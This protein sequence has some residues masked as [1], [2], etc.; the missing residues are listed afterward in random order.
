MTFEDIFK[1]NSVLASYF[2]P[3][4]VFDAVREQFLESFPLQNIH[5]KTPDGGLRTIEE[6]PVSLLTESNALDLDLRRTRLFLRFAV[7]NCISTDEYRAK[8]RPLLRQW[9]PVN[10]NGAW[11]EDL[12]QYPMPIILLYANSEVIDSKLFK[13]TSLIDKFTKDFPNVNVLEI[14]TVYKSPKEKKEFW[15]LVGQQMKGFTLNVF[16]HRLTSYQAQL[17]GL[18][19]NSP[20]KEQLYL[21]ESILDLY[22]AL[23]LYEEATKELKEIKECIDKLTKGELPK[24][25][26]EAPFKI[27][28]EAPKEARLCEMFSDGI[29]TKYSS[30]KYFF[31]KEFELLLAKKAREADFLRLYRL[32]RLFLH[33]IAQNYY[34]EANYLEFKFSLLDHILGHLPDGH[35]T[36]SLQ[37]QAELFSAKRD[38]WIQGVLACSS[39]TLIGNRTPKERKVRTF[40]TVKHTYSSEDVFYEN[41]LKLTK[42]TLS[43]FH[44]CEGK[45]Q[46]AADILSIEIGLLHY[47]REEYE[48]AVTLFLSCYEYYMQFKWDIIGL[49]LLKIFVESLIRCPDLNELTIDDEAVPVSIILSNAYLNIL[50]TS[51]SDDERKEW[52]QKFLDLGQDRPTGLVYATDGLFSFQT[53]NNAFY[54]EANT[55]SIEVFIDILGIPEDIKVDAITLSFKNRDDCFLHFELFDI[56]LRSEHKNKCTLNTSEVILGDF[57]PV[58]LEIDMGSTTFVK[59]FLDDS[60]P[61]VC[62]ERMYDS[63]NVQLEI[64]QAREL[65]LGEYALELSCANHDKITSSEVTITVLKESQTSAYPISFRQDSH[66]TSENIVDLGEKCTL[67]YFPSDSVNNFTLAAKFS[68]TTDFSTQKFSETSLFKIN[69][70]LPVSVSVEDIF[71]R[72]IFFFKF[73]LGS[74]TQDE[75]VIV[76]RT[77]LTPPAKGERYSISGGFN[78]D[79][80]LYLSADPEGNCLNCYQVTTSS[81]FQPSDTFDLQI[82]YSTLKEHL[83]TLVTDAVLV[84]GDVE[85]YRKFEKWKL[86]WKTSILPL[87]SY[88]YDAYRDGFVIQLMKDSLDMRRI[89]ILCRKVSMT[90]AVREPIILCLNRLTKGVRLSE[91]DIGAY[92]K[93]VA[94]KKLTVPVELPKFEQLFLVQFV[95]NK[96]SEYE[97]GDPIKITIIIENLNQ[98]WGQEGIAGSFVF[99]VASSNEWLVNGKRRMLITSDKTEVDLHIIPLK[100]GYLHYPKVEVVNIDSDEPSRI[101]YTN[102]YDTL[103]VF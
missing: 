43:L 45:R 35:S 62:I 27:S 7:V 83:D 56:V 99:E 69:C 15:G 70:Y 30:L 22:M 17:K 94:Q 67:P 74:S 86:L 92:S 91:I 42:E 64:E 2:D 44:L 68:F 9:L 93:N 33:S 84:R 101:D 18:G 10:E 72:D 34:A 6:V 21:R 51:R 97:L 100:R 76:S 78:P 53:A 19:S 81:H 95:T 63:R 25:S 1:G 31:L 23:N 28:Y 12:M 46:R 80:P 71:K 14:K 79:T 90:S 39:F 66:K 11:R 49:Q 87:L 58:S 5:W 29:L 20:L 102:Y 77:E 37:V 75:P 50:R 16:Q 60:V 24:G 73:L 52:W 57:K 88:Q 47:Q 98:T 8:V 85:W 13:S 3:F 4:D 54:S 41:Y 40:E 103:L 89:S 59:Q 82:S 36:G 65:K 32:I 48:K 61:G 96:A 26:L 55:L 38:C